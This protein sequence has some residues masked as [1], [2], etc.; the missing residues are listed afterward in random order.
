[1]SKVTK[2]I[3][4]GFGILFL[5]FKGMELWVEFRF[6][7]IINRNPDRAYDF[8]YEDFDLH[9]FFRGVTLKEVG[10]VPVSIDSGAT[11]IRGAVNY[12]RLD[13]L[14]WYELVFARNLNIGG[15]LFDRPMFKVT[16]SDHPKQKTSGK[17]FQVLFGDIISRANL[18][19]FEIDRGSI[20]LMSPDEQTIRG[21]LSNL[22][23]KA[24][25]IKTDSV[26]WNHLIPFEL[27]SLESS[28]DSLSFQL[29]DY[30]HLKTGRISF[31]K[32][33]NKL[34]LLDLN[35]YYTEE[36]S[37]V[38]QRVGKQTDLI[39][40]MIGELTF[41]NLNAS[42]D[43]YTDLDIETKKILLRDLIFKDLRDKNMQ[44]PPDTLKPMFKGMVDAIPIILS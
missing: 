33:D 40:V 23:V 1:M 39:E 2:R 9:S 31:R 3:L 32:R 19:R 41:E 20:I 10:I 30:T 37:V 28:I 21:R 15:I 34:T 4:I 22:M 18:K 14:K 11:V 43:L 36:L 12:A 38:S 6:Q 16:L 26:I 7:K 25:E 35:M 5:L 42:S 17:G 27:G 8:R 24:N 44:R 13:G 29:N